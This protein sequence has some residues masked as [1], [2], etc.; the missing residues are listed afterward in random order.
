MALLRTDVSLSDAFTQTSGPAYL[1]GTQALLVMALQQRRFDQARGLNTEGFISGYRGSPLSSVDTEAWRWRTQLEVGGVRFHPGINEDLAVTSVWGTQQVALDPKARVQGVFSMWYGKGA[2]LDRCGDAMRHAHGAGSSIHGGVLAVCGDDHALKSSS[3]AYHSE[4]T[5]ADLLMPVLYPADMQE[6]IRFGLLGWEMSRF[7]GCWIG[8][9]VLAEIVNSTGLVDLGLDGFDVVRPDET[10]LS[11]DRHIRWPDPW[12]NVERRLHEV[13][14]PAARAFARVNGVDRT[15]SRA[16]RARLAIVAPGKSYLDVV[17]ALESLG[18]S[19]ADAA[20]RGVAIYKVGMLW[21]LDTDPIARFVEDAKL[22]LVVEEKRDLIEAQLRAAL[23]DQP[24]ARRPRVIGRHDETGRPL[25]PSV[26]ELTPD[27]I[28]RVLAERLKLFAPSEAIDARLAALD[29]AVAARQPALVSRGPYFC[30]GC[31][32]STSTVVPEGSRALGGVGCHYMAVDME[33]STDT[34]TQ[35]GGEGANW[36]GTAP[37]T[38]TGHVFVNMGEG[39]YFHSGSLAIRACV[40]AGVNVTYKILFNDAVAMTGG[41]PVD[42][43]LTVPQITAQLRAEG[44]ER[45]EVVA[46]DPDHYPANAGFA[47]GVRIS[48]RDYLDAVQRELREVPGVSALIFDQAC[49]TEKRRRRKRGT[50][51]K[52]T[53]RVFINQAVCE[54]CGDC[55][56]KSNCLSVVPSETAL[57][58]KRRIDQSTC[59]QD[60]SCVKGFC[61]SFVTIDGGELRRSAPADLALDNLPLPTRRAIPAGESFDILVTGVG[62]SGVVTI[63]AVLGMAAHLEGKAFTVHDRLGMAQKFGGVWSHIRLAARPE[64]LTG[65]RIQ[66]R[67]AALLIGGDLGVTAEPQSLQVVDPERTPILVNTDQTVTGAFTRAPDFDFKSAAILARLRGAT[68]AGVEA[69][70]ATALATALL[71]D[72]IGA[73]M[74][75]LGFAWQRG[76]VPL[77]FEAIDKALDLNGVALAMN[78]KAFALGRKLAVDPDAVRLAPPA[79]LPQTLDEVVAHRSK[80]LTDWQ[81]GAY[82]ARYRALVDVAVEAEGRIAGADGGFTLAVARTAAKLMAYKDEYEVARL[83]ADPA[84]RRE[85]ES[86]FEGGK[87]KFHLA[88][89]LFARKDPVTGQLLKREY[90]DWMLPA[91]KLLARLRVLRGTWLDPFGR[92]ADRREERALIG[93]YEALVRDLARDLNAA[94]YEVA[95]SLAAAPAQIRGYGHVKEASIAK[96]RVEHARLVASLPRAVGAAA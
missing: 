44:V 70:D 25:F 74:L 46:E 27:L 6:M 82:A 20:E 33:R 3:Q 54:G 56:V 13:K 93:E 61:P 34:F 1:T 87:L 42:G 64:D 45:I 77:S 57:G 37:F 32:H 78:R 96:W 28:A 65:V 50:M 66:A 9:K 22:V 7:S 91:F 71:G 31:P 10:G 58:R 92:L 18:L 62:G 84:F 76:W 90:G 49:A 21:P 86:A 43:Q 55:G 4:P 41:Q 30:S 16:K 53:R 17:E 19:V 63:G 81:D 75:L 89:P 80:L 79:P 11:P 12:P 69:V 26:S 88:P 67:K 29:L 14:L 38:N 48:P 47:S 2:G 73:N 52:A 95:K 83:Y 68:K 8:F 40:A 39:T 5:F 24:E 36:I 59:N 35:M 72:A 94:N 23:Y 15:I 60:A 51:A 85:L